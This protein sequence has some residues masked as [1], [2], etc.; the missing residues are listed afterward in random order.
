MCTDSTTVPQW[1]HSIEKQPVFIANRVALILDLTTTD[2]SNYAYSSMNP[3]DTGTES[4][5]GS[6]LADSNW[7]KGPDFLRTSKWSYEQSE[8][9]ET[10]P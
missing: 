4:L 2:K 6:A 1:I 9:E 8:V 3:A 7:M 10:K 5:S